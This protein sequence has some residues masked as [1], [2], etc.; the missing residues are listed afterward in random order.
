MDARYLILLATV[1]NCRTITELENLWIKSNCGADLSPNETVGLLF[2][3]SGSLISPRH[4]LTAA[5]CVHNYN[6]TERLEHCRKNGDERFEYPLRN[7]TEFV[8]Y[9]GNK[10]IHPVK[11]QKAHYVE[12]VISHLQNRCILSS[13]IAILE[14]D[15]DVPVYEATPICLPTENLKI[16]EELLLVGAGY[17]PTLEKS[18]I[19]RFVEL[20]YVGDQDDQ[21]F[22]VGKNSSACPVR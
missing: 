4:I 9:V 2:L 16:A 18:G 15:D 12:R 7:E 10:C 6:E 8:V 22:V 13:D 20:F 17:N 14:L 3:C 5:H 19:L 21:G 11:C 1:V